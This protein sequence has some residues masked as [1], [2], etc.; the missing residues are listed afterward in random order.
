MDAT[1]RRQLLVSKGWVQAVV[2]VV[3]FGFFVLGLLAYRTYQAKPPIAA[4][5]RRPAGRACSTPR[6][7]SARASRSSSHNGLM[8]YGSVF[9]HGAYL[10][11]DFTADY[12]RRVV[13]L[14]HARLRRRA[15]RTA[16][17]SRTIEDFRTNRY[18]EAHRDA[19]ADRARR[20]RRTGGWSRHYSRLL[21]RA[22]DQARAAPER[23]HRPRP[24]CGS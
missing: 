8:E 7:T 20:P 9:G 21:L 24:S 13:G 10:G 14:R 22:D 23:D 1:G 4:A 6:T 15:A 17:R 16:R 18:D 19:D 12:L 3:L 11:P 2:L 5:R